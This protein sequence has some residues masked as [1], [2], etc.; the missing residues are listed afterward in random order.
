MHGDMNWGNFLVHFENTVEKS[1]SDED[2]C[3]TRG[4]GETPGVPTRGRE[5]NFECCVS[6]VS[7]F[8]VFQKVSDE[9][10]QTL[11]DETH[12]AEHFPRESILKW[13]MN[14]HIEDRSGSND[15]RKPNDLSERNH[16]NKLENYGGDHGNHQVEDKNPS[17]SSRLHYEGVSNL[18]VV[19]DGN[20][21]GSRNNR[22]FKTRLCEFYWNNPKGCVFGEKCRFAHGIEELKYVPLGQEYKKKICHNF[23]NCGECAFGKRCVYVHDEPLEKL[24]LMRIQGELFYVYKRSHPEAQDVLVTELLGL[25]DSRVRDLEELLLQVYFS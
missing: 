21:T 4:V 14:L 23:L 16:K 5:E 17:S 3:R 11:P 15:G 9:H 13:L 24:R 22:F 18:E 6:S 1:D 7:P 20:N 25:C 8:D 12:T 2:V 10:T 19:G